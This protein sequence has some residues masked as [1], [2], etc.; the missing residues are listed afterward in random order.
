MKTGDTR[1]HEVSQQATGPRVGR[2]ISI[3]GDSADE[4]EEGDENAVLVQ[5]GTRRRTGSDSSLHEKERLA[6]MRPARPAPPRPTVRRAKSLKQPPSVLDEEVPST[7][8]GS[9]E[10]TPVIKV[11]KFPPRVSGSQSVFDDPCK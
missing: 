1:H 8:A 10:Y 4:E 2:I 6:D 7:E 3:E 11:Q 9:S 5:L